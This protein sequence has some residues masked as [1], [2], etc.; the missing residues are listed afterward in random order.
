MRKIKN[1]IEYFGIPAL[2]PEEFDLYQE[3]LIQ[4]SNN[5]LPNN[6]RLAFLGDSVLR[7]IIREHFY[8]KYPN[9]KKGYLS[10]LCKG[11]KNSKGIEQNEHFKN[12]SINLGL[13][14]FMNIQNPPSGF[15]T[16]KSINAEVLEALCGAIYLNR[17]L[18]E[19]KK[20]VEENI[21]E[22][23]KTKKIVEDFLNKQGSYL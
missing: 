16:N 14:D 15:A 13:V 5:S 20:F 12:I 8:K 1:M 19:T 7:L 18:E 22:N 21:L 10:N 2:K 17:G 9:W 11:T 4:S 3:A 6:Q 23:E